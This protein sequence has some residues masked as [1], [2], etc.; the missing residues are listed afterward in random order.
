M[1]YMS[2]LKSSQNSLEINPSKANRVFGTTLH[3]QSHPL[4]LDKIHGSQEQQEIMSQ[5]RL[6]QEARRC[7]KL[8]P[9]KFR[10]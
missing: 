2:M 7:R 3:K 4:F 1:C 9:V 6:V 10:E 5:Q 8:G